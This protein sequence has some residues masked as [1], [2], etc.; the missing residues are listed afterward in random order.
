MKLRKT[1]LFVLL[2]LITTG[3]QAKKETTTIYEGTGRG[4]ITLKIT[5][6]ARDDVL[7]ETKQE[8]SRPVKLTSKDEQEAELQQEKAS[9]I[10]NDYAGVK[11]EYE[12]KD[13]L[14]Y[15][16]LTLDL[17]TGDLEAFNQAGFLRPKIADDTKYLSLKKTANFYENN[18]GLTCTEKP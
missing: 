16:T 2:L 4:G 15:E 9:K 17:V 14:I 8:S 18:Y 5:L 6:K 7:T 10:Y 12:I 1:I 11:H 13:G 3:C